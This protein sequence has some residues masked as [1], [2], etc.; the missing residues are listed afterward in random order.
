[1]NISKQ[2]LIVTHVP[3]VFYQG[4]LYAYGPYVREMNIWLQYVEEY[5]LVAPVSANAAISQIDLPYLKLPK[6]HRVIPSMDFTSTQKIFSST[7]AA[8]KIISV[9]VSEMAG[10]DHFHLRC[11]GNVG[12]LGTL[13]QI[14]F[15]FK[16]K[17]AK[18]AGNWDWRSK[19]PLSYRLQQYILRS[20]YLTSNMTALVYGNWP[21][22]TK[23]IKPFF[24]ATYRDNEKLSVA[25]SPI[26]QE[27]KLIFVGVLESYK[28]PGVVLDVA[29]HLHDSKI[30]F[31]LKF[32]GEGSEKLILIQKTLDLRLEG[33]VE[34]LGNVTSQKVKEHLIESHLLIFISRSEGWPKAVAESMFW[35]CVPIT[36]DVS[37]VG[38]MVGRNNE[39]GYL[40]SNNA[41]EIVEKILNLT[42][43]P[44]KF[45]Q[46]SQAAMEWS[47]VY[48]L[49]YFDSEI[50]KLL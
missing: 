15:P 21:D 4:Q 49:D 41:T 16:K 8:F 26:Q 30:K 17:T 23:N 11:P 9:L 39:R 6:K 44:E 48:T 40:V 25:K 19:Q 20:P 18:Y 13:V 29:K 32:C 2:F 31:S 22:L 5:V 12:L 27:V 34:F 46:M 35:G 14:F 37:C 38:D 24:T 28:S 43:D 36:T 50:K 33:Q 10:A 1:M 3:H 42:Q 45:D 7:V 47:R